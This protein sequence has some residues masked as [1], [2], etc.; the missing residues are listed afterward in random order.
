MF[1]VKVLKVT[2]KLHVLDLQ[3]TTNG[4]PVLLFGPFGSPCTMM[5]KLVLNNNRFVE[6]SKLQV[7]HKK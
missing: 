1:G 7:Q 2:L 6:L 3:S 5:I 4:C